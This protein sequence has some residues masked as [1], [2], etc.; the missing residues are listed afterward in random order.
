MPPPKRRKG[1]FVFL[2]F[3]F[4]MDT[5]NDTHYEIIKITSR[6]PQQCCRDDLIL[7]IMPFKSVQCHYQ[8]TKPYC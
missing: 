8:Y 7:S 6:N 1:V 2:E 5:Y 3:S 4:Q